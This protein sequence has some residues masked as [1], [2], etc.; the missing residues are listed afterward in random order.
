MGKLIW[1]SD[2]HLNFI[3]AGRGVPMNDLLAFY[4]KLKESEGDSILITGDIAESHN[5]VPTLIQMQQMTNKPIYFVLG[6]HDFYGSSVADVR[7]SVQNI[8]KDI[9]WI[10]GNS[11]TELSASTILVGV[12][13][14][15]DCRNGDYENS[16]ITMSDWIYIK[17][18]HKGYRTGQAELK[19]AI[20]KLADTDAR[21][22]NRSVTKAVKRGYKK[23]I[24]ATHV[25]PFAEACL[26]AGRKSTP[27]GL[28]FWS[29]QILGTSIE[30]IAKANPDVQFD[31]YCGHTHSG[32]TLNVLNNL[33]VNV[34]QA[35]YYDPQIAGIIEF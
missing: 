12:D 18:L 23:V 29:S 21:A 2:I 31:W 25:P 8:G 5:V 13:A 16:R 27:D 34:A 7:K 17:E 9:H 1:M 10:P 32:V 19:A 30:P 15:G 3:G 33:V 20:Q 22:L 24:I 14:W 35:D 4:T 26:Y 28:C 11:G 6:N